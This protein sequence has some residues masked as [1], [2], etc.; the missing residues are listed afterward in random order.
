MLPLINLSVLIVLAA[1]TWWL[2]GLDKSVNGESKRNRYLTRTLRTAAV[3]WLFGAL[4]WLAENNCGYGG[5][6]L[7]LILPVSIALILRSSLAELGT[8]GLLRLLDPSLHDQRPADRGKEERY[9]NLITH[10]VKNGRRSEARQWCGEFK[11]SGEVN[12]VALENLMEFHGLPPDRPV[13]SRP[14]A[15]AAQLRAAGK[16]S[17][18]EAR[19]R[20]RLAQNPADTAAAMML[21]RLC[22]EDLRQPGRARELLRSLEQ[23]P[24]V[25][26]SLI[27]FARRSLDDW[28]RP[29]PPG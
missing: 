22:A 17:E 1:L 12:P 8:H 27:E 24:H 2:T 13:V 14:L 28:C 23:Q 10:L 18:A 26:R 21:L 15:E 5:V 6:P 29:K 9:L 19:L 16:F 4:L 11:R 7:L 20:A 25:D 3:T